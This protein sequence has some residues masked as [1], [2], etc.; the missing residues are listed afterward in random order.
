MKWLRFVLVILITVFVVWLVFD[1]FWLSLQ[2]QKQQVSIPDWI[3]LDSSRGYLLNSAKQAHLTYTLSQSP[4]KLWLASSVILNGSH[5]KTAKYPYSLAVKVLDKSGEVLL[6]NEYQYLTQEAKLVSVI[7]SEDFYPEFFVGDKDKK[8]GAIESIHLALPDG[9]TT[10]II[11][12]V[13]KAPEILDVSIKAYQRVQRSSRV[14]A[15]SLW[16]RLSQKQ[17]SR[18]TQNYPF[19]T[20]YMSPQEQANLAEYRWQPLVPSGDEGSDY[21]SLLIYQIPN[22]YI[23]ERHYLLGR[24][25][26]QSDIYKRISFPIEVAGLYELRGSHDFR[27]REYQV[28]MVWHDPQDSY[29]KVD[30][31]SFSKK[32]FAHQIT[33]K[34]GLVTFTSSIPLSLDLFALS[35][36]VEEHE[37]FSSSVLLLPGDELHY[38]LTATDEGKYPVQIQV[39]ALAEQKLFTGAAA[40]LQVKTS[41]NGVDHDA[42]FITPEF[43]PE[44]DSQL[45][46]EEF[47]SWLGA[48]KHYYWDM[49]GTADTLTLSSN[50]PLLVSLYTRLEQMPSIRV[51][52]EEKRDWYDYPSGVPDWFA[53]RPSGWGELLN[54]GKI[55]LLQHYHRSLQEQ[56]A[57]PDPDETYQS[58]LTDFETLALTDLIV[59][60]PYPGIPAG[61]DENVALNF[62][63]ID[64]RQTI[65]P[66]QQD[67]EQ[68]RSLFFVRENN[69]P[70]QINWQKNQRQQT[71]FWVAGQWGIIDGDVLGSELS[72]QLSFD[73]TDTNWFFSGVPREQ[74]IWQKRRAL[75]LSPAEK[76][77]IPHSKTRDKSVLS[78]VVF[79]TSDEPVELRVN[80][81]NIEREPDEHNARTLLNRIYQIQPNSLYSGFQLSGRARIIGRQ[82]F[83][84]VLDDD[85]KPGAFMMDIEHTKGDVVFVSLVSRELQPTPILERFRTKGE[86]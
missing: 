75:R 38:P 31:L 73:T 4:R 40:K 7:D 35:G 82:S 17:K 32:H 20:S 45:V 84:V 30:T 57:E 72:G 83:S 85:I 70:R 65:L 5:N 86:H 21:D 48:A 13:T 63:V 55:K 12:Q 8:L 19:E 54:A 14:D 50:E 24:Y 60:N 1:R 68:S 6:E 80:L 22:K 79:T 64:S 53:L 28:K 39:R 78:L 61:L 77:T 58:L 11:E 25:Q 10:L 67:K 9:A 59:E 71:P 41:Q 52:P 34:P 36:L 29:K 42:F 74:A 46:N 49:Q 76:V 69:K 66:L 16:E 62:G 43:L 26:H 47:F 27:D 81:K 33:L 56:H 3:S 44:E 15:L 18:I 2:Q 37:H 51:L 23:T